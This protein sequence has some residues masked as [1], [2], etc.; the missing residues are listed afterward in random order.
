MIQKI[1]TGTTGSLD[2]ITPRNEIV[3]NQDF[4]LGYEQ[5]TDVNT[6]CNVEKRICMSG[7]LGGTFTQSSCRDDIVYDYHK[8]EA[9]SY[10]QKVLN[11]YIQP[12]APVNQGAEFDTEG[13]INTTE[14]STTNR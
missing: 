9:I 8:A 3:K 7:T 6:I 13:K 5:R 10:N 11:E 1:G 4:V 14:T 2:C 12:T